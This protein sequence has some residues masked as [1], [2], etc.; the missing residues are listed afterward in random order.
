MSAPAGGRAAGSSC[1][2]PARVN[3]YTGGMEP[4]T[5]ELWTYEVCVYCAGDPPAC[6]TGEHCQ[7]DWPCR[8]CGRELHHSMTNWEY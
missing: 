8:Q 7:L 3:R 1:G 2:R 4:T 6:P 5:I